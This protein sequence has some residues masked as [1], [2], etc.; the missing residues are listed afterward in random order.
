[1]TSFC[2]LIFAIGVIGG[3]S[4]AFAQRA[5]RPPRPGVKE[6]GVQREMSVVTPAAVFPIEGT[7]DW[8]VLTEDSV[9]V[10]NGP[11]NTIHRLDART[12][13]VVAAIDVGKKPCSGL[14]AGFG[15]IWVPS[16]G[17]NT[18]ARVDIKTNKLVATLPIGPAN[19][20]GGLA[21]SPD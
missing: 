1:M 14:A 6:P 21:T 19:S 11:K 2:K 18:L 10:A 12:N 16:C 17:D 13:T 8:Q 15:S 5:S 20:E 7:P 3:A 9:W 4:F